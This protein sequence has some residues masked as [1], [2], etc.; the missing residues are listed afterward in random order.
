M[1]L[2]RNPKSQP[3]WM[4]TEVAY[5]Y[6]VGAEML[7]YGLRLGC[8]NQAEQGRAADDLDAGICQEL[9]ELLRGVRES[10]AGSVDPGSI[11]QRLLR[12]RNR[13]AR[14]RPRAQARIELRCKI[15]RGESEA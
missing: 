7:K 1:R 5:D 11:R 12:D 3:C 2:G 9:I 13:G 10:D 14:Y 15:R 6:S 8:S 4:L